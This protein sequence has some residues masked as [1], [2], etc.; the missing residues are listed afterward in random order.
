MA[1]DNDNL[2][3][4]NNSLY[5][6]L[7]KDYDSSESLSEASDLSIDT[8]QGLYSDDEFLSDSDNVNLTEGNNNIIFKYLKLF[9]IK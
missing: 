6:N 8:L 2:S 9:I 5:D 4:D 7:S 3:E 1:I